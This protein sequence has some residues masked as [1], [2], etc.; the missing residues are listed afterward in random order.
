LTDDVLLVYAD[1]ETQ[2]RRLIARDHLS[3]E[4]AERRLAAQMPIEEKR[5]LATWVIDNRGSLEETETQVDR[6]WREVVGDG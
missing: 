5:R 1:R 3:V 6:W 4:D 2:L